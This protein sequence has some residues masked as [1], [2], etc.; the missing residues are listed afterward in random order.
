MTFDFSLMRMKYECFIGSPKYQPSLVTLSQGH[1]NLNQN[2][3]VLEGKHYS[4]LIIS[5]WKDM[6]TL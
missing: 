1:G 6:D 2:L 5:C 4:A 3:K